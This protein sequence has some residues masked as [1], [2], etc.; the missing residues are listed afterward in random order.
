MTLRTAAVR[1]LQTVFVL[2]FIA[3]LYSN[4]KLRREYADL[5]A[6]QHPG[7]QRIAPSHFRA[8]EIA[9]KLHVVDVNGRSLILDPAVWPRESFLLFALPGCPACSSEIAH[10]SQAGNKNYTVVSLVSRDAGARIQQE[11]PPGVTVYFLEHSEVPRMRQHIDK[12]P[13]VLRISPGGRIV[14][15][16]GS[17]T[18]CGPPCPTCKL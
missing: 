16:C 14:A 17:M 2:V 11:I 10:A 12:V 7:N 3:L 9:P 6:A 18:N 13:S 1:A 8:G 15:V 4:W 5:L